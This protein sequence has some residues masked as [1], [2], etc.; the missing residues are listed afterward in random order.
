M[1]QPEQIP[2]SDLNTKTAD[3]LNYNE[4]L[5]RQPPMTS[6]A[7]PLHHGAYWKLFWVNV[8]NK[9]VYVVLN[10]NIISEFYDKTRLGVYFLGICHYVI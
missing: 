9:N 7:L 6:T 2:R 8:Y 1:F 4:Q 5:P 3:E 10:V